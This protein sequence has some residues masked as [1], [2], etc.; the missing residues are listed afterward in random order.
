MSNHS[1]LT[2]RTFLSTAATAATVVA[3]P[4]SRI[5]AVAQSPSAREARS[6]QGAPVSPP[7]VATP[8]RPQG[9]EKFG[10]SVDTVPK[11][12]RAHV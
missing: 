7:E 2:R 6:G 8:G 10:A 1:D 11:I 9:T 4:F 12:G 5:A 3:A